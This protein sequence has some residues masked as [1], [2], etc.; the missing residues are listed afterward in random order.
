MKI[1]FES[2]PDKTPLSPSIY[3]FYLECKDEVTV[4]ILITKPT[5]KQGTMMN[6]SPIM[7]RS[8]DPISDGVVKMSKKDLKKLIGALQ[9]MIKP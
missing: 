8:E 3:T 9:L 4:E 5:L 1:K 7:Q 6:D 2:K